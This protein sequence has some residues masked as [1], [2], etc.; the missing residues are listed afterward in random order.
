MS[1]F[2]FWLYAESDLSIFDFDVSFAL[3]SGLWKVSFSKELWSNILDLSL[4]VEL[5][6]SE[7]LL[8]ALAIFIRPYKH[9]K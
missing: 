7:F 9:M 6:K 4:D 1:V 5:H 8:G 2:W 3:N